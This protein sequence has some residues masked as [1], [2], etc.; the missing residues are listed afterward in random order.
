MEQIKILV[1]LNIC[2]VIIMIG[3]LCNFSVMVSNLGKMPVKSIYNFSDERHFSFQDNSQIK[4]P[5]FADKIECFGWIA[6]IGDFIM[7]FG[8]VA[9]FVLLG[10]FILKRRKLKKET[11]KNS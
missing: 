10:K 11:F 6:S 1:L 9:Y 5:F 3:I 4:Y 2:L 7:F 8:L